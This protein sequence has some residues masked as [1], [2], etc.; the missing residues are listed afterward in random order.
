MEPKATILAGGVYDVS[1]GTII[2][3]ET[4]SQPNQVEEQV[5]ALAKQFELFKLELAEAERRGQ[6]KALEKMQ[7]QFAMAAAATQA[8]EKDAERVAKSIEELA[9]QM[10]KN[11][12]AASHAIAMLKIELSKAEIRETAAAAA[13]RAAQEA[14]RKEI[15]ELKAQLR[16]T[17]GDLK[18]KIYSLEKKAEKL[19]MTLDNHTHRVRGAWEPGSGWHPNY[20]SES[21]TGKR[22]IH[23]PNNVRKDPTN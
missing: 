16:D 2:A 9:A 5:T 8:K 11:D 3:A 12:A 6:E 23:G 7:A 15:A 10:R 14:S 21:H 22:D 18:T 4:A 13:H 19:E 17:T 20:W 1:K